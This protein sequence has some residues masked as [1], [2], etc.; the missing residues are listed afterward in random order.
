[1]LRRLTILAVALSA[2][3]AFADLIH[4]KDGT[5]IEGIAKKSTGGF[6]VTTSDGKTMTIASDAVRSISLVGR[7]TP[8]SA[9]DDRLG[10]LRR[11]SENLSDPKQV[12]QRYQNFIAQNR[13]ST[14][15]DEA[16]KDLAVWQD[17]ADRR[18]VKVGSQWVTPQ[19]RDT[20]K[21]RLVGDIDNIRNLIKNGRYA[22]ADAAVAKA[23]DV[24][25][26]NSSLQF[27]KGLL[28]Y[29]QNQIVPSRK[30]F[31]QANQQLGNHAP[32]LNNLAVVAIRQ[33]QWLVALGYLDQAM[34]ASKENRQVLDNVA[35]TLN[36]I[37]ADMT[38]TP[39]AQR[40]SQHFAEQDKALTAKLEKEGLHRWG[41][42]WVN[43]QQFQQLQ[44][45][46][47]EMKSK[48]DALAADYDSANTRIATIDQ[49]IA[50]NQRTMRAY[51][52]VRSYDPGGRYTNGYQV[53][54]PSGYYDLESENSRLTRE[55][56]EQVTKLEQLRQQARSLQ[57]QLPIPKYTGAVKMIDVEGTPID[58]PGTDIQGTTQPSAAP[59]AT[60]AAP[61]K[62]AAPADST[63]REP[64][65]Q[66][67]R[68]G[69]KV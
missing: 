51:E 62:P 5:T 23:S 24:D 38:R 3:G 47:K 69:W 25:P 27:L 59:R 42:T 43:D 64:S 17:R 37:P 22:E 28:L 34:L 8:A 36:A 32:T 35:E 45:A 56:A 16:S 12:V 40:V 9:S 13:G 18:L 68:A 58:L 14:A 7:E 60:P 1:M 26:N 29:R 21:E 55:R 48:L 30:S 2:S 57:K 31:E 61:L 6:T 4:L 49:T 15:A 46:E 44:A 10:S 19:E 20:L 67:R 65:T 66:P 63:D 33:N 50:D 53:S 54:L 41:A 52:N 39:I 11:A